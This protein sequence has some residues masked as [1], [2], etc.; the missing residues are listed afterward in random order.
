MKSQPDISPVVAAHLCH[1]CGACAAS[2]G[3]GAIQFTESASG[4]LLPK[5]NSEICT[6]CGLCYHVCSG[7]HFGVSLND[8]IPHDPFVGE[9]L[10][11]EVGRAT[12]PDIYRNSQSGGVV[13]ALLA[14]LLESQQIALAIVA[15]M[16]E[17]TPPR[18]DVLIARTP[19]ELF[20]AQKSKYTPIPLLRV[21][22]QIKSETSPMAMVGLPCHIHSLHNLCDT[23]PWLAE[24]KIITI[25]LLCSRNMTAKAIDFIAQQATRVPI[26]QFVFRD[27]SKPAY[28][29][30]PYAVTTRN[31]AFS[32]DKSVRMAAK[33]IFT[34][35]RCRLCFDKMNV[36]ADIACGDP[37]G[38]QDIDRVGGETLTLSRT[39][40]GQ[41]VV[42][43]AKQA[44]AVALRPCN[45][46]AS[47]KGQGIDKKRKEFSAYMA[48][49]KAMGRHVPCYPFETN[50]QANEK[51]H[52]IL[53]QALTFASQTSERV[54]IKT[55]QKKYT[56]KM[57]RKKEL[58]P[59]GDKGLMSN[60]PLLI[61]KI[62]N[63]L[64]RKSLG[65]KTKA[66]SDKG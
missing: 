22:P 54:V 2:C 46:K 19:D 30:H 18:G 17:Q 58:M 42:E 28:P 25:G 24:K 60:V 15:V 7:H 3:S 63:R 55:A 39:E 20:R 1:S 49:W 4:Y 31:K 65:V 13:T 64:R 66:T 32:L 14:H 8:K 52:A 35:L 27:K 36:F 59:V 61:Q 56:E 38:L 43:H 62:C 34:P 40:R 57:R 45:L 47:L 53:K 51:Q 44:Q 48:A 9:I 37:H 29:G 50:G 23:F 10:S 33:D 26:K 16:K 5:I 41:A 12:A 6:H 21:L 11:C